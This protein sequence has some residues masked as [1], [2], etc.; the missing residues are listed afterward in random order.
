M[1]DLPVKV[2]ALHAVVVGKTQVPYPGGGQVEPSR[3]AQPTRAQHQHARLLQPALAGLAHLWQQQVARIAI[4]EVTVGSTGQRLHQRQRLLAP[5]HGAA[6]H[7][8][9]VGVA[10]LQQELRGIGR[11]LA[12]LADQQ[13]F[14]VVPR[15]MRG[16]VGLQLALGHAARALGHA[17]GPFVRLAHIDQHRAMGQALACLRGGNLLDAHGRIIA[18]VA[19]G[20]L[21]QHL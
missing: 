2:A 4:V 12:T 3:C 14:L 19:A 7:G 10:G 6:R 5:G 21:D 8:S 18:H 13:D 11:A 9:H 15:Q 17:A 20:R 1:H 16:R